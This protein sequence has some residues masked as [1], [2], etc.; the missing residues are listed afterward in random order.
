MTEMGKEIPPSVDTQLSSGLS[1]CAENGWWDNYVSL[2]KAMVEMGEEIPPSVDAQLSSGLSQ[3]AEKGWW[4]SYA[5]LLKVLWRRW[6][7]A[8]DAQLLLRPVAVAENG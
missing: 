6:G 5:S 2:L 7:K 4:G 3:C 8:T 1:Q